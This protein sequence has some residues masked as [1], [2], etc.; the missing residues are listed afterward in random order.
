MSVELYQKISVILDEMQR[1][2][3]A[4]RQCS[5][6]DLGGLHARLDALSTK[7]TELKTVHG[8]K[9]TCGLPEGCWR[10]RSS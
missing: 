4:T 10:C 9:L 1:S 2:I 5:E 8:P 6:S 3:D 7:I